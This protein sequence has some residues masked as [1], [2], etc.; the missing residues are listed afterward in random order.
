MKKLLAYSVLFFAV[1]LAFDG[2]KKGPEDPFLSFRS[3]KK[4]VEGYWKV[5]K[6]LDQNIDSTERINTYHI[7]PVQNVDA[8]YPCGTRTI[9]TTR[10]WTLRF[11]F[12]GD[13]RYEKDSL[14][15]WRYSTSFK[16]SSNQQT[17]HLLFTPP[18]LAT[19]YDRTSKCQSFDSLF[20]DN[21]V[22]T[23]GFWMFAG[24]TNDIKNKERMFLTDGEDQYSGVSYDIVEL[25][26]KEMK[27]V[28]SVSVPIID[29]ISGLPTG[30]QVRKIQYNMEETDP[31]DE[32]D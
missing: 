1:V 13:G 6:Y 2:C 28:F 3:R 4:R 17:Y 14:Y 18:G 21:K 22:I 25:R 8:W 26:D 11:H 12:D 5:V 31:F 27:L 20:I 24:G 23:K 30:A 29:P 10:D 32:G 15:Q 7:D 19:P 9:T 16:T